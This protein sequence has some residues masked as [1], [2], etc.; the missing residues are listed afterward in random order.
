MDPADAALGVEP[1]FI[2]FGAV[3]GIGHVILRCQDQDF[4]HRDT[5]I[6]RATTLRAV[7]I[8]KGIVQDRTEAFEINNPTQF[9]KRITIR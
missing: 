2:T 9:F 4:E 1:R 5:V 7:R 3:S 6:G 8:G